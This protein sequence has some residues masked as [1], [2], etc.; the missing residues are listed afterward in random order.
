MLLTN[1]SY[2][3]WLAFNSLYLHGHYGHLFL[4]TLDYTLYAFQ[5][6]TQILD[7]RKQEAHWFD[8]LFI[9]PKSVIF[10]WRCLLHVWHY[11]RDTS[12]SWF[13]LIF[14][15]NSSSLL[16]V[17]KACSDNPWLCTVCF[18]S[19]WIIRVALFLFILPTAWSSEYFLQGMN[20]NRWNSNLLIRL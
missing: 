10:K 12:T 2:Y 19:L 15:W 8:L 18:S 4:C 14:S 17:E 5:C 3:A 7:S 9:L 1:L 6:V 11:D 20:I 16:L 13:V